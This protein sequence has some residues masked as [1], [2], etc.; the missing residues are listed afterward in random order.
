MSS[1]LTLF[2]V[3]V[4][5]DGVAKLSN[6]DFSIMSGASNLVFSESSNSRVGS[7]RWTVPEM[8]LEGSPKRTIQS[9]VYALGMTLLV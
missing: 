5:S 7:L 9:D 1:P 3:L 8:L 4:S 6:F 2:N